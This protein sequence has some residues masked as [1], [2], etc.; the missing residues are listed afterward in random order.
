[1]EVK[2]MTNVH[3]ITGGSSGIGLECAKGFKDGK[4]LITGR[5]EAKLVSA[6]EELKGLGVDAL[7]KTSDISD[8]ASVDELF[9]YGKS[10]GDVKTV[11]NSAGV[12][13][14]GASARKTFEIDLLGTLHLINAAK[15]NIS[16]GGVLILIS[17]MMG[18]TVVD[19]PA[20]DG[21]LVEPD[22]EGAI[23]KLVEIVEDKS[24]L[25][26]NFSK[27][28]VQLMVRKYASDF[29][30]VGARIVS[31][32]PGIIMTPMAKRAAED[33]ADRMNAMEAVTPIKRLGEPEDI[34]KA[35]KFLASDDASFI[36]GTDLLVDGGLHLK[37]A[38]LMAEA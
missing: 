26:Y 8:Q 3:I 28:A 25:A 38:E 21:L 10:L 15:K 24:D 36:T 34:A 27:K 23:D 1:M 22:A 19:N 14:V 31:I 5:T 37:L 6:C 30:E 18:H 35:V 29:G 4:V 2:I 16:P 32:S 17:S 11:L 7:Y 9:A 13:G 20:Y 33:Y 12:S